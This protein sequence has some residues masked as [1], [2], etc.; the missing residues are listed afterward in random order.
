MCG[1]RGVTR[2]TDTINV[3]FYLNHFNKVR[4][5]LQTIL[6]S[7]RYRFNVQTRIYIL[8]QVL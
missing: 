5:M 4:C 7:L 8:D 2:R 1:E 6:K 3:H